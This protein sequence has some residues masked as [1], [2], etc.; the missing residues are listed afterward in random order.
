HLMLGRWRPSL[1]T[2]RSS[3][4]LLG[5]LGCD[6]RERDEGIPQI[7]GFWNPN[8]LLRRCFRWFFKHTIR[9]VNKRRLRAR[10]SSIS[11]SLANLTIQP[12]QVCLRVC[13]TD[14][15]PITTLELLN[16][17]AQLRFTARNPTQNRPKIGIL[18]L[19]V[20]FRYHK[21]IQ[22]R[23]QTRANRAVNRWARLYDLS[24]SKRLDQSVLLL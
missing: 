17:H 16:H 1:R 18:I 23:D 12:V 7:I 11:S 13:V 10:A 9:G 3:P 19:Q 15:K 22:I 8:L 4:L 14:P 21:V 6:S 20:G 24:L 5:N 2:G